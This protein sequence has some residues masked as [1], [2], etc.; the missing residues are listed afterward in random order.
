MKGFIIT[1]LI[2][3]STVMAFL[4]FGD[5]RFG[6]QKAFPFDDEQKGLKKQIVIRFSHVVAENTPKGLASQKFAELVA[7]KTDGLVKVEVYPNGILYSDGEEIDALIHGDIQMAAPSFTKMTDTVPQWKV[8]DLPYVFRDEEHIKNVFTGEVGKE[9]LNQL[10]EKKLKGLAFWSNGFKQMTSNKTPLLE[11]KDFTGQTFRVMEGEV[12]ESQFRLLQATP[13]VTPFN[14]V[15]SS[16]EKHKV[17]GQENTISNIY[18]KRLY[19]FQKYLTISNHGF[20]GYAVIVNR[21]F[22]NRLAPL[23]QDQVMEA[24]NETAIW[25][26][27]ESK[28][29]NEEQLLEIQKNSALE[30]FNLSEQQKE[31]WIQQFKPLYEEVGRESGTRLLNKIKDEE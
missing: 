29:M 13:I 15:Y 28:R 26:L 9:L 7:K 27:Y 16:L 17:D 30:I 10:D 2:T 18:S 23:L 24:M 6:D 5:E 11:T 1:S 12:L 21:E 3:I 20:L 22:W 31:Q 25:N 14:E 19:K 4:L 8:M